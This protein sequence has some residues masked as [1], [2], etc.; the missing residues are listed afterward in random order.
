[1]N[2]D[3]I[4]RGR[5]LGAQIAGATSAWAADQLESVSTALNGR[6]RADFIR[7]KF[8]ADAAADA[9]A[10]ER[11][12][13]AALRLGANQGYGCIPGCYRK[14]KQCRDVNRTHNVLQRVANLGRR[15]R[16][17]VIQQRCAAQA[18]LPIPW[19]CKSMLT[20]SQLNPLLSRL[21]SH[22]CGIPH[23]HAHAHTR[24]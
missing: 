21:A 24:V 11:A 13:E 17:T 8:E 16:D 5:G 23:T 7:G 2:P 1:M 10:D 4:C 9:K 14:G 18:C 19:A 12:R 6:R 20:L 3:K 22:P 15:R